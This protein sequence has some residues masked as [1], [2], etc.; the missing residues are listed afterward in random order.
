MFCRPVDA[1]SGT[2]TT[3]PI[4]LHDTALCFAELFV[5]LIFTRDHGFVFAFAAVAARGIS[6]TSTVQL[7][8]FVQRSRIVLLTQ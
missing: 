4:I 5:Y 6:G 2:S 8:Q 3:P 7:L 1:A